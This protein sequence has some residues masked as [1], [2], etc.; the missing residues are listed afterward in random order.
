MFVFGMFFT[1]FLLTKAIP[2]PPQTA[3]LEKKNLTVY[4]LAIATITE[5]GFQNY[6]NI[7][8]PPYNPTVKGFSIVSLDL[9][10]LDLIHHP[11]YVYKG[12][13][14]KLLIIVAAQGK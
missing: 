7:N 6:E 9:G 13:G 3:F 11:V 5:L 10:D 1:F 2:P 4:F 12:F 14:F 8:H